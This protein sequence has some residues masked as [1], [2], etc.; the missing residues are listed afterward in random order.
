MELEQQGGQP[1]EKIPQTPKKRAVRIAGFAVHPTIANIFFAFLSITGQVGMKV[2]LPLWVDSTILTDSERHLHYANQTIAARNLS[3]E[4]GETGAY[5]PEVDAYFVLSFG[6]IG[7]FV[8]IIG[9]AMLF[10]RLFRPHLIGET[11]RNFPHSQIF[12]AG[13]FN[14]LNGVFIVFASSGTRTAPSLQ[15][16]LGNIMIPL[17][18]ALRYFVLRKKPTVLKFICAM[19][20]LV[21]LFICLIPKIFTSIDPEAESSDG[22]SGIAGILWPICYMSGSVSII[23]R[24][25]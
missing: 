24:T 7:F 13:F 11:E 5:Q 25:L 12:L 4:T 20:V 1:N 10:I 8:I 23:L 19:V 21:S 22:A 3:N 15:A 18:I 14:A 2:T 6:V 17:I 9:P 16:I